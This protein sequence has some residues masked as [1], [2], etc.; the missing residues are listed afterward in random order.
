V[1]LTR[2]QLENT[3]A[4]IERALDVKKARRSAASL[5]N[6]LTVEKDRVE[7]LQGKLDNTMTEKATLVQER[8][9]GWDTLSPIFT[10]T[11]THT[12]T[13]T[14]TLMTRK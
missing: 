11:L 10:L 14:L 4:N 8:K 13:D 1:N 6:A 2:L 7:T 9:K 12:L 5:H 3:Q